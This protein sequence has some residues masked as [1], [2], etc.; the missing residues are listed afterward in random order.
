L[1]IGGFAYPET[2]RPVYGNSGRKVGFFA[3][4]L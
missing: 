2:L 1:F 3:L 4:L